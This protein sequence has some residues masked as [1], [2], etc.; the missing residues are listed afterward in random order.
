MRPCRCAKGDQLVSA[1][2]GRI[3][4]AVG[5]TDEEAHFADAIVAPAF[6]QA[7]QFNRA[8][9]RPLFILNDGFV[10]RIGCRKISA[11]PLIRNIWKF[12][13]LG[14]PA[15]P[16]QIAIDQFRF[17]GTANFAARDDV[18]AHRHRRGQS[19][20]LRRDFGR[21]AKGPHA[22]QIV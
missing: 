10:R 1:C 14:R 15:N 21:V 5:C 13:M 20:L 18:Q 16:F 6:Q 17:R 7:C 19:V 9:L 8:E 4:K 22:F 3:V 12:A 2:T 11:P